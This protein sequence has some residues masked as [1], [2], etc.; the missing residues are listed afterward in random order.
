MPKNHEPKNNY[1]EEAAGLTCPEYTIRRTFI[2]NYICFPRKAQND[3]EALM[4]K[5][6]IT[7]YEIISP[8]SSP[9]AMKNGYMYDMENR[10]I[11]RADWEILSCIRCFLDLEDMRIV[12]ANIQFE[13]EII[14]EKAKIVPNRSKDSAMRDG[15]LVPEFLLEKE[16]N[17]N[18]KK[19]RNMKDEQKEPL[20]PAGGD[21]D[22][23]ERS[24]FDFMDGE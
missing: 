7:D 16:K 15:F 17:K 2:E 23:P 5:L 24:P 20:I 14:L 13:P 8:T 22:R 9:E 11:T 21:M 3:M 4:K 6:G 10:K 12:A 1:N 18:K 19:S